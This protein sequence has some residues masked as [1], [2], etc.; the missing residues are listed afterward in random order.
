MI[1]LLQIFLF[2]KA[3]LGWWLGW[4]KEEYYLSLD[5]IFGGVSSETF[6][7]LLFVHNWLLSQMYS[8]QSKVAKHAGNVAKNGKKNN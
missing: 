6:V 2:I 1:I 5:M 3:F 4:R 8:T 7:K